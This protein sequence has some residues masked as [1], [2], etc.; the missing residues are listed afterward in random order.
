M[1]QKPT[2]Q[3][4]EANSEGEDSGKTHWGASSRVIQGGR[5]GPSMVA[6][7]T[8]N[9]RTD[10]GTT[11][12]GQ[13]QMEHSS[14]KVMTDEAL[15]KQFQSGEDREAAIIEL[16]ERYGPITYAFLR[17]RIGDAEIAAEM[18]QELYIGVMQSLDRFRGD[19]SLKTWLFRLAHHRLS[20]QRRRWRTHL[21]ELP[22]AS[23]DDLVN[24]L[25]L[26]VEE[27]PDHQFEKNTLVRTLEK[28]LAGLPE[29]QR[30]VVVGQYY[31][32]I[33]LEDMTKNLNLTNKSGARASLIAAQRKLR[34]CME[35]A[36]MAP[37][38]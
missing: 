6:N 24:V 25:S 15:V 7:R 36:G 23:P 9:D 8:Y 38:L 20:N 22:D 11:S 35:K 13:A 28:C 21:D 5:V 17:R 30:A 33:T 12:S 10:G 31:E 14:Q 1:L 2:N 34:R 4:V 29:V 3:A 16:F 37:K 26:S 32:G 18:N 27:Q 19:S